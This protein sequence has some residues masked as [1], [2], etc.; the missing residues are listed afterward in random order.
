MNIL[1]L[2]RR[3]RG[4]RADHGVLTDREIVRAYERRELRVDPFD[5]ELLRP[6]ALSLRLGSAAAVLRPRGAIDVAWSDTHPQLEARHPDA[7]G[8]LRLEPGEVMLAPTLERVALSPRLAGL[9][10]GTSDYARL[11][12]SVVLSHQ[13]SPGYGSDSPDGAILT[14]E[15]VPRLTE[16]VYLRP[17]TRISNLMLFHCRPAERPYPVMPA[18]YSRDMLVRAS[19]V[20]EYH[21]D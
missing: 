9:I 4:G 17:G 8:R 5:P 18:N 14:L 21:A 3:L 16:T 7:L 11:G 13:V 15:I 12:I 20:A 19:R 1:D 2:T 10:D 6:A